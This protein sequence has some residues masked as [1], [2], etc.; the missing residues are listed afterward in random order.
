MIQLFQI[1]GSI[2]ITHAK[3]RSQA[4]NQEAN[5]YIASVIRNLTFVENNTMN[6]ISPLSNNV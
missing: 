4:Y 3:K 1:V 2:F 5:T 6:D